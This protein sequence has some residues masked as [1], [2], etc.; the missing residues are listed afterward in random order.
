MGLLLS[1]KI[2]GA[3]KIVLNG[4]C[5]CVHKIAVSI[6]GVSSPGAGVTRSGGRTDE[7]A[8]D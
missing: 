7:G 1:T 5:A 8:G 2:F 4:V 6:E 3:F